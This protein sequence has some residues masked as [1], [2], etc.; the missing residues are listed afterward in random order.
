MPAGEGGAGVKDLVMRGEGEGAGAEAVRGGGRLA[1]G[2][3]VEHVR[4]RERLLGGRRF[5]FRSARGRP[6]QRWRADGLREMAGVFSSL[7]LCRW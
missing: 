1:R 6:F 7:G 4:D 3:G 5:W 2:G